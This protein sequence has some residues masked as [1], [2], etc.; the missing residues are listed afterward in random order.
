MCARDEWLQL[1]RRDDPFCGGELEELGR[2]DR[3]AVR[4]SEVIPETR[5][6]VERVAL[7]EV[8]LDGK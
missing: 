2:L 7:G 5:L 4:N 1:S 8:E 6:L 3:G